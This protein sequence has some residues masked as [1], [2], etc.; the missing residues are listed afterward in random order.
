MCSDLEALVIF[1]IT[2]MVRALFDFITKNGGFYAY[3]FV[4][5]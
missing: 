1:G 4:N 5:D 3:F 2:G